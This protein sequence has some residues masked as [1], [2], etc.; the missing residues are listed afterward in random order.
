MRVMG[1]EVHDRFMDLVHCVRYE[2]RQAR[3]AC[4][5]LSDARRTWRGRFAND[6]AAH[7]TAS[8]AAGISQ[9]PRFQPIKALAAKVNSRSRRMEASPRVRSIGRMYTCWHRKSMGVRAQLHKRGI[10][11]E[12]LGYCY[13]AWVTW[14]GLRGLG[15]VAGVTRLRLHGNVGRAMFVAE[16]RNLGERRLSIQDLYSHRLRF[17]SNSYTKTRMLLVVVPIL[18]QVMLG[19]LIRRSSD[20]V[21]DAIGGSKVSALRFYRYLAGSVFAHYHPERH[22]MRGPGPKWHERHLAD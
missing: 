2:R 20:F 16:P 14:L 12:A 7:R 8:Q 19:S 9:L 1:D 11:A 22:Y 4:P 15:Y 13:M 17:L 6:V 10:K 3:S 18:D 21:A 5:P